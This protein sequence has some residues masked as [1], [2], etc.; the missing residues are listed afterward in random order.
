[1]IN[2]EFKVQVRSELIIEDKV[3]RQGNMKFIKGSG[4]GGLRR[5]YDPNE[6]FADPINDSSA[7][8]YDLQNDLSEQNNL[9]DSRPAEAKK[10][11][12]ELVNALK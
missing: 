8:L 10:M 4:L 12:Q 6:N 2:S 3:Y 11:E 1:M 9:Y 7:E 5:R